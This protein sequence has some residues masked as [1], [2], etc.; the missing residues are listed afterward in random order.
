[1]NRSRFNYSVPKSLVR[2]APL[3]VALLA[4][5]TIATFAVAQDAKS[6]TRDRDAHVARASFTD[7]GRYQASLRSL[8]D[9]GLDPHLLLAYQGWATTCY[10][11]AGPACPMAVALPP[12][13]ACTCYIPGYPPL[14]GVTGY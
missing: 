11:Y 13:A 3:T 12:G 14:A 6:S 4:I 5:F 8:D 2:R 9:D 10:T 1:V 7:D